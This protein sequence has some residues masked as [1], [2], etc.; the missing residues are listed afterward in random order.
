M[1][2]AYMRSPSDTMKADKPRWA[3][4]SV[5]GAVSADERHRGPKPRL[6]AVVGLERACSTARAVRRYGASLVGTG[7]GDRYW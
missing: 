4:H 5:G 7:A 6:V 2:Q 3:E 1:R